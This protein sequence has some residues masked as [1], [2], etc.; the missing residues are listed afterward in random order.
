MMSGVEGHRT[1]ELRSLALHRAIA[2]RLRD[3][4]TIVARA[5]ERLRTGRSAP[6]YRDAWLALLTRSVEEVAEALTRDDEQMRALRQA[7][8]FTFVIDPRERWKLWRTVR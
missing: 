6:E 7:T 4:P 1:A 5:R 8:P 3:D 2:A